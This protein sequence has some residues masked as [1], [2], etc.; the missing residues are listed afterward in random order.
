MKF[1]LKFLEKYPKYGDIKYIRN[2]GYVEGVKF[3]SPQNNQIY[4][5]RE[6]LTEEEK[7]DGIKTVYFTTLRGRNPEE[8]VLIPC[9][10]DKL[11]EYIY[12]NG[13]WGEI[14]K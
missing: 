5:V 8:A 10:E 14:I 3:K 7:E 1:K 11:F 9:L 12:I 2:L 4:T 13:V 6:K